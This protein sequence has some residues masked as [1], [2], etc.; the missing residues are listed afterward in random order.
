MWV[1]WKVWWQDGLY[2]YCPGKITVLPVDLARRYVD[3]GKAVKCDPPKWAVAE[4]TTKKRN[5][6]SAR[7]RIRKISTIAN[8][9]TS[10]LDAASEAMGDED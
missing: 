1:K 3:S 6:P 2:K 4:A 8:T 10:I 5:I 7:S 9:P